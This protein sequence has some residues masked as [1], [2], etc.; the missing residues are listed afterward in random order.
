MHH[1]LY[2]TLLQSLTSLPF[3]RSLSFRLLLLPWVAKLLSLMFYFQHVDIFCGL[4]KVNI[5]FSFYSLTYLL[6]DIYH[7]TLTL[8]AFILWYFNAAM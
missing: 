3:R 6:T 4:T 2:T 1:A 7:P 8:H 5:S